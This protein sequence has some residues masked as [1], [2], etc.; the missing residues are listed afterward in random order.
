MNICGPLHMNMHM[1]ICMHHIPTPKGKKKQISDE[2]LF[3]YMFF[4]ELNTGNK[5]QKS[6]LWLVKLSQIWF[7]ILLD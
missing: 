4:C 6:S 5:K 2:L 1:Y 7:K 3:L